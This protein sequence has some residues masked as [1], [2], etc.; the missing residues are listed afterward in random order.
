ML[1]FVKTQAN[2]QVASGGR[3][4]IDEPLAQLA[5]KYAR[6]FSG[7]G[8]RVFIQLLYF[9]LV[10]N[11]LTVAEFGLFATASAVGIVLS[12]LAGFGFMS[13]LYRIATVK[14]R[15]IGAYTGGYLIALLASLPLVA[16]IGWGVH[17]A[18]FASTMTLLSFALIV[19]TE[20]LFW[21][22]LEIVIT[23]NKGLERFGRASIVIVFGFSMKAYAAILLALLPEPS[24]ALWAVIYAVT[25][26]LMA[27]FAIAAFYPR[28]RLRLPMHM[29]GRRLHDALSV[30]AS[31]IV[32]YVQMELDKLIVLALGGST[33]AGIYAII[34]R[35]IDLT[36]VP[37]RVFSTLLTQRLMRRPALMQA[38]V[39]RIGFEAG[40]FGLSTA[41]LLAMAMIF[42]IQP[43]ILGHNVA[44]AGPL[45]I[46]VLLVPAFRN[47]IE[48]Q[49]E[50]LYGRGQTLTRLM[51]FAMVGTAKAGLMV[52]LLSAIGNEANWLPW[53]NAVFAVLYGI[54]LVITYRALGKPAIRV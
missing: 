37:V 16:L 13:P 38:R 33:A 41:G 8:A 49:A 19:A 47:L 28:C 7:D 32:F 17:A 34:M 9:Y 30:C 11:T 54:S 14:P 15:L 40:I 48:Y 50:L 31:D 23:V 52:G 46:L 20:V 4:V 53:L 44:E 6:A 26:A 43:D 29:F 45:L 3:T 5:V 39:R 1:A 18:L 22:A 10:A 35:L 36:A 12:R 25:Q 24:L 21:R 2:A 27:I 42:Y 51:L